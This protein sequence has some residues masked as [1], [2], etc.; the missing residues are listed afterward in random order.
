MEPP[1]CVCWTGE[2]LRLV[3]PFIE[4][5]IHPQII[6]KAFRAANTLVRHQRLET[7]YMLTLLMLMILGLLVVCCLCRLKPS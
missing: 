6:I 7:P 3:K 2:M 5:G 1:L 4:D